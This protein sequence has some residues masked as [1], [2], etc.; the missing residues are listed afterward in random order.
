MNTITIKGKA[1]LYKDLSIEDIIAWCQENGET[2]W[3]KKKVH[4]T[5]IRNIYP[6]KEGTKKA[7]KK[8]KPIGNKVV[9]ISFIE[10]KKDF[11]VK[12]APEILPTAKEKKKSML[13]LV[14]AL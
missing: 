11:A 8:A 3:L 7:D 12:F 2:E 13:D 5:K 9:P 4:E 10:V 6:K 1:V 14:D